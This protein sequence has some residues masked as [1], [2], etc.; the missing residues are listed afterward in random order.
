[1]DNIKY[2]YD[3]ARRYCEG[4]GLRFDES[5]VPMADQRFA[6]LGMTQG[7]VTGVVQL[8]AWIIGWRFNPSSYT[9]RQR[10]ALAWHFLFGRSNPA[11]SRKETV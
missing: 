5:I 11:F 4:L 1:M 2:D 9:W 6:E 8:H 7:E 3:E 10:I